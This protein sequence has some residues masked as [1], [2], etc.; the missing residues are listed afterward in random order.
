MSFDSCEV[1]DLTRCWL[2]LC[3]LNLD[4]FAIS[5]RPVI[6]ELLIELLWLEFLEADEGEVHSFAEVFSCKLILFIL[7]LNVSD[8]VVADPSCFVVLS[9]EENAGLSEIN[10]S[11]D[12]GFVFIHEVV[13]NEF[14][15]RDETVERPIKLV[16]LFTCV[17]FVSKRDIVQC[18][19]LENLSHP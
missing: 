16:D 14:V 6:W 7:I 4:V 18:L 11:Y 2:K 8:V 15:I 12:V 3:F 17:L 5:L 13:L 1:N 9:I 19:G 10:N